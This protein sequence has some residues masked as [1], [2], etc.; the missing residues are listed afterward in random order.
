MP[1]DSIS[2]WVTQAKKQAQPRSEHSSGSSVR[3]IRNPKAPSTGEK[4][5]EIAE[6]LRPWIAKMF[7]GVRDENG[8]LVQPSRVRGIALNVAQKIVQDEEKRLAHG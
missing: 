6:K 2:D 5:M 4:I 3:V 7:E 1:H 8:M